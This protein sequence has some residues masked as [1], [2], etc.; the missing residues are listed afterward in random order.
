MSAANNTLAVFVGGACNT[1]YTLNAYSPSLAHSIISF[2]GAITEDLCNGPGCVIQERS[3]VSASGSGTGNS[4]GSGPGAGALTDEYDSRCSGAGG[5]YQLRS[6]RQGDDGVEYRIGYCSVSMP[7][8]INRVGDA[9]EGLERTSVW[10]SDVP[11]RLGGATRVERSAGWALVVL[12][13]TYAV[14]SL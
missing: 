8:S 3:A 13:V 9:M 4:T 11:A 14:L 12:A 1:S 10:C 2:R 5:T 6:T 7:E